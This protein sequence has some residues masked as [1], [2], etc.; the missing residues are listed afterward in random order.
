MQRWTGNPVEPIWRS[1]KRS[2]GVAISAKACYTLR[3]CW[4]RQLV[5]WRAE[6]EA[7]S[8]TEMTQDQFDKLVGEALD[9]L[10]PELAKY[11]DNIAVTTAEWPS[12]EELRQTGHRSPYALLGLYQGVPLTQRGRGYNL[13]PPD[14]IVLYQR[15]I[16]AVAR[17]A[18]EIRA[19]VQS[20]VIHEVAHHFGISDARLRELGC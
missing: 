3:H 18:E 14:R 6:A 13:T 12:R 15:P 5:C 8:W 1:G 16:E 4:Q 2:V 17:T 7:Q 19:L 11:M 10:P 20:T 9:G